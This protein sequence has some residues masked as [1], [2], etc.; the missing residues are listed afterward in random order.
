LSAVVHVGPA[1]AVAV[2][3][4]NTTAAAAIGRIISILLSINFET[5][6]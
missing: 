3:K 1:Q 2:D 5:A 4:P 6:Q